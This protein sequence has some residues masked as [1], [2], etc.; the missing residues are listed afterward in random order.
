MNTAAT[1]K[2]SICVCTT[3]HKPWD[4]RIYEKEIR[5]LLS[6]FEVI[7]V[8]R[9]HALPESGLPAGLTY[10]PLKYKSNRVARILDNLSVLRIL[11]G[12]R[13]QVIAYHVHDPELLPTLA[14]LKILTR[15]HCIFDVHENHRATIRDRF[16]IPK[17]LR[18]VASLI[19]VLFETVSIPFVDT[20]VCVSGEIASLYPGRNTVVLE[21]YPRRLHY[22]S[23]P[24]FDQKEPIIL[25]SGGLT[26]IRGIREAVEA[27]VAAD[28]PED[29]RLTLLGWFE[30]KG[31]EVEILG[32]LDDSNKRERYT[33]HDWVPYEESLRYMQK[34]SIGLIPY[35]DVENHRFGTP[36][37]LF[38]FMATRT[39]VVF[40]ALPNYVETAGN[41]EVGFAVDCADP[42]QIRAALEKLA[43]DAHLREILGAK[44]RERFL[45]CYNWES[46]QHKLLDV[47]QGLA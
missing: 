36:N 6:E 34:A 32:M 14:W 23:V 16:W 21:N 29:F 7:Y 41:N 17:P 2:S 13:H 11:F 44:G 33:Y 43:G 8:A 15:K 27:F 46:I 1:N 12:V 9:E 10:I 40:N 19:F 3:V 4:V 30:S 20:F 18:K 38:E 37:K 28:L 24:D 22:Q 39:A 25:I 47:Y 35:L 26:R 5:T 31:F 42:K 45:A